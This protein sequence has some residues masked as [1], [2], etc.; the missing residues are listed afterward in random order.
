MKTKLTVIAIASAAALSASAG[1]VQA[2]TLV[3][4]W[5][6]SQY[7]GDNLLG[8]MNTLSA[9]YSD[10]DPTLRAGF[11]S[12]V[13]GTAHFDG[14]FT[15][16]N[17]TTDFLPTS[18]QMACQRRPSTPGTGETGGCAN[19]N[20]DG[21]LRSNR[22][23][24]FRDRGDTAFDSLTVQ[25]AEGQPYAS[26]VGMTALSGLSVVFATDLGAGEVG[27]PY[28]L[29]FGGK[30][31]SGAGS[32]G[33]ELGCSGACSSTVGIDFSTDG[34]SFTPAG[35]ANLTPDDN[36]FQVS[37]GGAGGSRK[38]SVRLNFNPTSAR[39]IIDN[40]AVEVGVIPEPG[41]VAQILSCAAG[42]A[43]LGRRRFRA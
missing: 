13:F 25:K 40:V 33:G 23:E 20:V 35:S 29:S 39:P 18:G 10:L 38:G 17:T 4:G 22:I 42:L 36:R 31:A 15:S 6:F 27:G 8:G 1:S 5:D 37:L 24:P 12:S 28:T 2:K 21:P 30:T 43:F 7:P 26:L 34:V 41:A 16:T 3:A 32:D 19:P 11:E 14:S 9:N